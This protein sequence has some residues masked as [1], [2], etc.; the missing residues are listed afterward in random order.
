M[1][2]SLERLQHGQPI[3]IRAAGQQTMDEKTTPG[4]LTAAQIQAHIDANPAGFRAMALGFTE[5]TRSISKA[6]AAHDG[7][8]IGRI[9][10]DLDQ[11]CEGCHQAYWYP[12]LSK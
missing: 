4:G 11:A 9:A 2:A 3:T 8:A 12:E 10:D 5:I 1:T 7:K 6:A